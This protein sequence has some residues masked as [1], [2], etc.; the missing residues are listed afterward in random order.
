MKYWSR[1]RPPSWALALIE[2]HWSAGMEPRRWQKWRDGMETKERTEP[3][4]QVHKRQGLT[5]PPRPPI[6]LPPAPPLPHPVLCKSFCVPPL[7]YHV[8]SHSTHSSK[9]L[10]HSLLLRPLRINLCFPRN[11]RLNLS[12]ETVAEGCV[13]CCFLSWIATAVN[14]V[15]SSLFTFRKRSAFRGNGKIQRNV[16]RIIRSSWEASDWLEVQNT[17]GISRIFLTATWST[18]FHVLKLAG[19]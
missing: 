17:A 9:Q 6:S 4:H 1:L 16:A 12:D 3:A 19:M 8:H 14:C 7:V 2:G 15:L 18:I 5:S 13:F 10:G 11:E